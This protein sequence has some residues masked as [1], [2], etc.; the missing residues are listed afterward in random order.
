[1]AMKTTLSAGR[2]DRVPGAVVCIALLVLVLGV[3]LSPTWAQTPTP[4]PSATSSASPSPT[5]TSPA[6][7]EIALV[8]PSTGYDPRSDGTGEPDPPKVSDRDD[9]NGTYRISA[10]TGQTPANAVVEAGIVYG[11]G[12]ETAIGLLTRPSGS[13]DAWSYD[14]DIPDSLAE[15]PARIRV[16]LFDATQS[17]LVEVASDEVAVDMRHKGASVP[18]E[19]GDDVADDALSL[20]RPIV[21]GGLGFYKGRGLNWTTSMAGRVSSS[22]QFVELFYSVSDPG[23]KPE[24]VKCGSVD[25]TPAAKPIPFAGPCALD[26]GTVPQQVTAVAAV[27]EDAVSQDAQS[28]VRSQ[29]SADA[30][31]VLPYVQDVEDL[32]LSM[33]PFGRALIK[34]CVVFSVVVID[35]LGQPVEGA[36]V[37][38]HA[39]GP[40]DAMLFGQSSSVSA[41]RAPDSGD[42]TLD[43]AAQCISTMETTSG[44][45]G[46]HRRPGSPDLLHRESTIGTGLSGPGG[47]NPVAPGEWRFAVRST[48]PGFT[49]V[50]AWVDD[51]P[52][53]DPAFDRPADDDMLGPGD[54]SATGRAQFMQ[55]A[56][57]ISID[58]AGATASTGTCLPVLLK[59][60]SGASAVPGINVDV[61]ATGPDD[62]LDFC[63]PPEASPRR[64]PDLPASGAAQHSPED[65]GEASHP[66]SGGP[67]QQHTE[68][69]TDGSG[70]ATIGL[71]SGTAQDTAVVAWIDGE[72]GKDN[73]VQ[74]A[75]EGAATGTIS[76]GTGQPTISFLNPSPYGATGTSGSGSGI[77]LPDSGGTTTILARVVSATPIGGVEIQLSR[78]AKKT[79]QTLG[80]AANVGGTDLWSFPWKVNVPDGNYSL[81]AKI[82]DSDTFEDV[83][84]K[85]GAGDQAPAVPNPPYESVSIASPQ[86]GE[87]VAFRGRAFTVAAT[88][89]PGAEGI[90]LFYTKV[91]AN[92]TP[93]AV[94]W[95]FCGFVQLDG[96]G[97]SEQAFS[98]D[99]TIAD[100]D[101]AAQVTGIAAIAFDC[102]VPGCDANPNPES[103]PGV[104]PTGR[105][106]G[107]KETGDAVRI[108]GAEATPLF[109][110]EPAEQEGLIGACTEFRIILKDQLGSGIQGKN[111]DVHYSEPEDD[112]PFCKTRNGSD[113]SAATDGGHDTT[114][115]GSAYHADPGSGT[116][117]YHLESMTSET[118][119]LV[120]GL[121]AREVGDTTLAGWVDE[122]DDDVVGANEL[123]DPATMH[124]AAR[125]GCSAIGTAG[126]DR[127][128]GTRG[129]DRICG[130]GGNDVIRS[131]GGNDILRGGGGNDRIFG[132]GGR[133]VLRGGAGKDRMAGGRGRDSCAGGPGSDRISSC[134]TRRQRHRR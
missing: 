49:D 117:T 82:V 75:T 103:P 114:R 71:V 79:F 8:N 22:T 21:G 16:H 12:N 65:P 60:R 30:M 70:N 110:I 27:A 20:D 124:W 33:N 44:Q 99:C 72:K 46:R 131:M 52:L 78:D 90:D 115:S 54:I 4:T 23:Q 84:V 28:Q 76:W 68:T 133:D 96:T 104:P 67:D 57:S 43:S 9:G 73:D 125:N 19:P 134:Y 91:G 102:T 31:G 101:Q 112:D 113:W 40:S 17:G 130:G 126:S 100:A 55:R 15:G 34:E 105:S 5:P 29:E 24:F 14:W 13:S 116:R 92:A 106:S 61:H 6:K 69:E 108:F 111:V 53:D 7:P 81:R 132:G 50:T 89:S 66:S 80:S 38:V 64:A 77:Q 85:V 32:S 87:Q 1:M 42:H 47:T 36:N 74:G 39:E 41:A 56:P 37:D 2:R 10:W 97:S 122:N 45:L 118:G 48:E 129:R 107:Q 83:D 3:P 94:D 62:G 95:I 18:Q 51:E 86:D 59:V 127:M 120:F 109:E 58:P 26:S 35:S 123:Q 63:D 119:V 25:V 11:N 93:R 128:T 98:T 88:A 121:R